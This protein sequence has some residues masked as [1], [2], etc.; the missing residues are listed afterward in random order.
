MVL[1]AV[2]FSGLLGTTSS[3]VGHLGI[4]LHVAHTGSAESLEAVLRGGEFC[5]RHALDGSQ[6]VSM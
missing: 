6:N 5:C 1:G 4:V 3:C 2:L